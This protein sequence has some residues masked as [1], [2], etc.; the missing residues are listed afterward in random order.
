MPGRD[1]AFVAGKLKLRR[2]PYLDD[3]LYIRN[4]LPNDRWK[5]VKVTL[6]PPGW[7]H[8][9]LKPEHMYDPSVYGS[10]AEMLE[11]LS[12]AV[13]QEILTLYDAGV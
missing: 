5:D 4:L 8:I 7:W 6:L 1:S 9:Q 13:R 3:W 11:D 12:A 2:S 10:E